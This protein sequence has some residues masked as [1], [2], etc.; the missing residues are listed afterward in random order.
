[1]DVV[2]HLIDRVGDLLEREHRR[3]HRMDPTFRDQAV[4][5]P[6]LPVVREV[7]ALERLLV[8]PEV[9]VVVLDHEPARGRAGDDGA[10]PRAHEHRRAHGRPPR[11]FEHDV[12]IGADELADALAEA[13][14]LGRVLR[15]LVLPEPEVLRRAVDDVLDAHR[16]QHRR[17][18]PDSTRR[19]PG[20][21]PPLSTYWH[22]YA[23]IPPLAPQMRTVW[24]WVICAPLRAHQ[25]AVARGVGQ[26]VD[27]GLLPREVRGLRHELAR[28]DQRQLTETAVVGL[29]PPDALVGR[30]H[31]VVVRA[32][33][34]VVD[35]VAVHGDR[36][37]RLPHP[38]R[39]ADPEHHAGGV[40]PD[41]VERL[42]VAGAPHALASEPLEEPEGGD[43]LEDRRPHR[44]EVD[45]RRHHRDQGLV[46]R[47]L[48]QR[49]LVDVQR[50]AR[51]LV[52]RR[53]PRRT[54]PARRPA[55]RLPGRRPGSGRAPMSSAVGAAHDRGPDRDS[56]LTS[57]RATV[58]SK[59]NSP[60][61][62]GLSCPVRS[63]SRP[64]VRPSASS[65]ARCRRSRP[66]ISAVTPS[67]PRCARAGVSRR[68][69][70]L[71]PPGS[72]A[73]GRGRPDAGAPGRGEGRYPH[74]GAVDDHQ[75]GVPLGH[76]RD[77][78]GRSDDPGR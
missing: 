72:G 22:A 39:G 35:V 66:P 69:G 59:S 24:P 77:L 26:R 14:P 2:V 58:P 71:R 21:P 30:E 37:A 61:L 5:L 1:M 38:H 46:G 76:Q 42:V 67:P 53:R 10:A 36:V 17:R 25:H 7:T 47:Q 57:W 56:D 11:V 78:P 40:A 13:P 9:A 49:H 15:V 55:P 41:H 23:P 63:S 68:S 32:R 50:L 62:R 33:V 70:R 28:L 31:R 27:R 19:R 12:G 44:V 8:H 48:G 51:V 34:L 4:G 16:V 43:G 60:N 75:Q 18:A 3:Q 65:P 6:R 45:R 73:A 54:S 20:C 29:V 64:P 52:L 74:V